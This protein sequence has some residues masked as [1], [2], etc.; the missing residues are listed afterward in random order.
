MP[1]AK[2]AMEVFTLATGLS[3][4]LEKLDLRH[5]FREVEALN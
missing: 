1:S 4:M 3:Q 5:G 2:N